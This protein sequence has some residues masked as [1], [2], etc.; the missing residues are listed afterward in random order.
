MSE[1]ETAQGE[2]YAGEFVRGVVSFNNEMQMQ[3]LPDITLTPWFNTMSSITMIAPSPDWYSGFYNVVPI[4]KSSMTWLSSFEI[5]NYPWDAGTETGEAF[6]PENA[7]ENPHVSIRRFTTE[8]VPD[9]GVFLNN[10]QTEILPMAMWTCEIVANE[11]SDHG[12]I[13]EDLDMNRRALRGKNGKKSSKSG[14]KFKSGKS[15]KKGKDCKA[16]VDGQRLSTWCP[17]TCGVCGDEN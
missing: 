7:A 13:C 10:D 9:S 17:S 8:N 11:C 16:R 1:I 14:K 4:D 6:D 12:A 5:E 3:T 2:N 15:N